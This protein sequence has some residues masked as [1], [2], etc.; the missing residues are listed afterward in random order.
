MKN[1]IKLKTKRLVITPMTDE[2]LRTLIAETQDAD[3]RAAYEEMRA[4]CERCEETRLWYTPWKLSL[5]KSGETAG[6]LSFKGP[7]E[8]GAVEIGYGMLPEY[9]GQGYMTEAVGAAVDWAF[10]Q[11]DVYTVYAETDADN[12]ASARVLEKQSFERCGEGGEGPR[13]CRKKPA[14]S[15]IAVYMCLG[16][17]I[18]V[19]L[20]TAQNNMAIGMCMGIAIGLCIGAALDSREKKHRREVTGETTEPEE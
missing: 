3:V 18:G 13:Y 9:E 14:S 15:W 7:Q 16:V 4:G 5:K 12:A 17:S 10:S 1:E 20:G 19:S 8:K 2:E 6:Y 11:E